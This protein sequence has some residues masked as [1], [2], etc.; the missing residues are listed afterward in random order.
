MYD[1]II[2]GSGPAGL[3]AAIYASRARL[4]A[5]VCEKDYMGSGQIAASDCV[6]NYPA[7]PEINGYELGEKFREHAEK[8]GA[9]FFEGEACKISR[10][11]KTFTVEFKD[12]KTL[13][14]RCIIYAAGTSYRRLDAKG[15]EL[16]G[17]SYCATCDGAFYKEK[18]VAVVGGGDTALGDAL[19]LANIAKKVYLVHRRD[20]FRG[21]KTL[22]ELV[23]KKANIELVTNA[24]PTKIEGE[25]N[26]QGLVIAQNGEERELDVSGV[27]VAI[28]SVPNT[29][30]LEGIC[31]LDKN[32]YIIA[33]EDG[34]TSAEGIFA[35]GDVRTKSLRQVVTAAS[36]GANSLHSAENYLLQN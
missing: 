23:R 5:V 30:V 9:E 2:I 27:F 4:S 7:L 22:Q 28:G 1:I 34:V 13:D 17:V 16:L 3:T 10:S 32:G 12:G 11:G 21:N 8:L 33:G 19:Y 18:N 31:S 36:D 24:V 35:A 29:A 6:D 20:E 15:S 25:K 26:V 14:G